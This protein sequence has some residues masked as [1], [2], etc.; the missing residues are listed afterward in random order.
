VDLV[1]GDLVALELAHQGGAAQAD[2][3]HAVQAVHHQHVVGAKALH[4][5]RLDAD[6]VGVEH[7]HQGVGGTCRVGERAED[8][9]DRAHAHLAPHRGDVLH[10][11][12]VCR[13]VHE[14]D[15]GGLDALG[16]LLRRQ[17][18]ID[19]ERLDHV[20]RTRLRR[21]PAS[22]VLGHARAGG[23]GDE[24]GGGGDVEGVGAVAAG[25]DD[26]EEVVV[27]RLDHHLGGHLAHHR[28]GGGDLADGLLLDAQAGE[29]GGGHHRGDLAGHDLAHQRQHLVEEDLAVLDRA[30]QGLLGGDR[31]HGTLAAGFRP[32]PAGWRGGRGSSSAGRGRTR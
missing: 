28:G 10:R 27:R 4:H 16:D 17:V 24:D 1:L 3:V 12:V 2:L 8:V 32:P 19:A 21:H 14:A 11:A 18:Q 22:A 25:A 13:R 15:A 6:Q 5:A 31:G 9:E 30:L 29:D 26:V 23:S 7:P 20:G